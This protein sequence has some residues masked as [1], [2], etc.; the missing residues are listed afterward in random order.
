MGKTACKPASTPVNPNKKLGSVEHDVVVN[1]EMHQ[2]LVGR[3]TYL[4]HTR[5]N[6]AFVVSLISQFKEAQLQVALR[7]GQY[8]KGT[9]GRG[10]LS[11]RNNNA[12]LQTY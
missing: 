4:S 3:L 10:I 9:P 6:I 5:L 12:S 11:K 2:K 7:I 1:K 8:L